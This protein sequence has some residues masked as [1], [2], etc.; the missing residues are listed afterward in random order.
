MMPTASD[1]F[2]YDLGRQD[3]KLVSAD[4]LAA[5]QQRVE[6]QAASL[7]VVD[8]QYR[9]A[10]QRV[11]ALTKERDEVQRAKYETWIETR[12]QLEDQVSAL[13]KERDEARDHLHN[14]RAAHL[15]LKLA[16]ADAPQWEEIAEGLQFRALAAEAR[17]STL[18]A[19][20]AELE[21][22]QAVGCEVCEEKWYGRVKDGKR[23]GICTECATGETAESIN[24]EIDQELRARISKLEEALAALESWGSEVEAF[25][26]G[27]FPSAIKD[28]HN[29]VKFSLALVAARAALAV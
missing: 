10:L 1:A 17:V 25:A 22:N 3:E 13:T 12:G 23:W 26:E 24:F 14:A 4:A 21:G 20:K 9:N 16:T 11:S 2:H 29:W 15:S 19:E 28:D 7:M 18:E 6:A 27:E 5:S 8:Q